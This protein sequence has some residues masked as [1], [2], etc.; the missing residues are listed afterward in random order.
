MAQALTKKK[1]DSLSHP[2]L[3]G[4]PTRKLAHYQNFQLLTKL[5]SNWRQILY[6][7]MTLC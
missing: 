1:D 2:P 6:I 5:T 7:K 3:F 4:F